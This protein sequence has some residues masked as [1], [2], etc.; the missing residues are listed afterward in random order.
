[1]S[2]APPT[3]VLQIFA[4]Y[5]FDPLSPKKSKNLTFC[6]QNCVCMPVFTV[7]PPK[8][9]IISINDYVQGR[10]DIFGTKYLPNLASFAGV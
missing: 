9:V 4:N 6:C 2:I 5:L 10:N 7:L 1:M 3:V 8:P